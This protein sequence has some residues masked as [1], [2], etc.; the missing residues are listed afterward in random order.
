[1]W[2]LTRD[3]DLVNGQSAD[4]HGDANALV[5]HTIAENKP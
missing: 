1:M 4:G 3:S 2:P 5:A